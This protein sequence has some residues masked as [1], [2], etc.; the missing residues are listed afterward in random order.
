MDSIFEDTPGY[1]DIFVEI[2]GGG[3]LQAQVMVT[4]ATAESGAGNAATSKLRLVVGL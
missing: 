4:Y 2:R 3:V 1:L